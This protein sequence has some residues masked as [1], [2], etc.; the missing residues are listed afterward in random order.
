MRG[1]HAS[2]VLG[3]PFTRYLAARP[4]TVSPALGRLGVTRA[5]V[6]EPSCYGAG[7]EGGV[8]FTEAN[9]TFDQVLGLL[10]G[11]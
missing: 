6:V 8:R 7:H 4:P 10:S 1:T 3:D 2:K 9:G 11:H 5:E